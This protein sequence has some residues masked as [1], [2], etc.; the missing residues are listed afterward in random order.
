M[1]TLWIEGKAAPPVEALRP[2]DQVECLTGPGPCPFAYARK[3]PS[4]WDIVAP[5]TTGA[6]VRKAAPLCHGCPFVALPLGVQRLRTEVSGRGIRVDVLLQRRELLADLVR[7]LSSSTKCPVHILRVGNVEAALSRPKVLLGL[8]GLSPRQL[9]AV[10]LANQL[11][12]FRQP[13]TD[14]AKVAQAM[15]CSK[16]T[17]HEHLQKG[18]DRLLAASFP[19]D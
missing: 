17:A 11:G 3:P 4:G 10:Q 15:G 2:D 13:T 5:C 19:A 14:L 18:L 8:D 9:E 16:S 6:L 12:Y 1:A 7:Q